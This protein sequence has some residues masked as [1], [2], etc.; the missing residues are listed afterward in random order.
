MPIQ[1]PLHFYCLPQNEFREIAYAVVGKAIE[2]HQE[3]I[4]FSK[5]PS[6]SKAMKV[7]L[8]DRAKIE[9]PIT[10]IFEDFSKTYYLDLVIDESAVFEL[11]KVSG[12][13][14]QHR[15]QLL[16]YLMLTNTSH[17]KLINFGKPTVEHEFVNCKQ[18]LKLRST[19]KIDLSRWG[20]HPDNTFP[21]TLISL[22]KDWGTGLDTTLYEEAVGTLLNNGRETYLQSFQIN[23][24]NHTVGD[25]AVPT[26][27]LNHAFRITALDSNAQSRFEKQLRT[28]L[29]QTE[30]EVIQWA[31][32]HNG[33]VHF[34]TIC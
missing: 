26:L 22:L 18:S 2:I 6:F 10:V 17:G 7:C 3:L 16:N 15:S 24:R 8:G 9:V 19:S 30:L 13:N 14:D 33:I 23:F 32:I 5:E 11:K 28:L 34:I 21:D 29:T 12:I 1:S 31:N 20:N 4:H 25:I 27:K